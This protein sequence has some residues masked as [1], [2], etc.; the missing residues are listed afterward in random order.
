MDGVGIGSGRS[1]VGI[2][3]HRS[4]GNTNGLLSSFG[5]HKMAVGLSIP[6]ERITLL[7]QALNEAIYL[8]KH[9]EQ[10]TFH[11][12][13]K[14]SPFDL[15]PVFLNEL[16]LLAPFGEGNPEPVF[17][18]PSMEIVGRK[19]FEDG[20][21]KLMLRHSNRVFHTL[22][23]SVDSEFCEKGRCLDVAFSPVKIRLNGHDY[24]Y[25]SLKA[26]SAS[27]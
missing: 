26:L 21:T 20:Q 5:G 22:R 18:I 13:L 24:L 25:L 9:E 15:T 16:E 12:D 11:V 1:L 23:C 2:D 3:L 10:I 19:V 17:L 6:E 27:S 8:Q 4:L 14:I 7:S